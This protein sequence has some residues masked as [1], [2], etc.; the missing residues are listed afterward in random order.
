MNWRYFITLFFL[1]ILFSTASALEGDEIEDII[2]PILNADLRSPGIFGAVVSVVIDG[3]IVFIRGYGTA[4]VDGTYPLDPH[5]TL[6]PI[7]S[8][9]KL[10]TWEA[11]HL[12]ADEGRV[13][14]E[15][16]VNT[17]LN[18][19]IIKETYP[20][21]IT[22]HHLVTHTAGL[23]EVASGI[24]TQ[25]PD[26]ILPSFD[27]YARIQPNRVRPP[28]R[29][30]AYSNIG[31][32]LGGAVIE[33]VSKESYETYVTR[34]ILE[35]ANMRSTAVSEPMNEDLARHSPGTVLTEGIPV[36]S[37][38]PPSGGIHSTAYDMGLYMIH[39]M[40]AGNG[41]YQQAFTHD[42]R[43]S[44]ITAGG[45]NERLVKGNRVLW[46]AGD[47][48]GT[49]TLLAIVP[50]QDIGIYV[51]YTGTDGPGERLNLMNAFLMSV[52]PEEGRAEVH[53][54][55]PGPKDA[56]AGR[57]L[58]SRTPADG[59]ERMVLILGR[60]EVF[61]RVVADGE[62]ILIGA[63]RYSEIE[64]G[65]FVGR[66]THDRLVFAEID[67]EEW[68]FMDSLPTIGWKR[69]P[70]SLAPELHTLLLLFF[71]GI[72]LSGAVIG[73]KRVRETDDRET[74]KTLILITGVAGSAILFLLLFFGSI[75]FFGLLFGTPPFFSV[76]RAIP[77]LTAG[78]TGLLLLH[79]RHQRDA[80]GMLIA[81]VSI[82]FLIWLHF[83][84]MLLPV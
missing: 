38:Y 59:F 18:E 50:D 45:F 1:V 2:D 36:Y 65:Y 13:D 70:L 61:T 5:Q 22:L 23:D 21:P 66:N 4:D 81:G 3:E 67:G 42:E 37:R 7:G 82:L 19:P 43:L 35:P 16:D 84:G 75:Q 79:L 58:S 78:A 72:F 17:Y 34:E 28:G 68:L 47:V 53:E 32:S 49:S 41:A 63:A 73:G 60:D 54:P 33:A 8:V 51:C 30:A 27:A 11:L 57:Y 71:G 77:I 69:A 25:N 26:E 9:S 52:L 6:L 76:I 62:E 56:Y 40:E 74:K 12:L 64:P 20:E 10:F 24:F 29:I 31:G 46:H 55:V 48:P 14:F 83:W 80:A 39:R 44:G 15:S